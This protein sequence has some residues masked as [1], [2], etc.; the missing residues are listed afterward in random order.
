MITAKEQSLLGLTFIDLFAGLGG[1][2]LA[3][4]SFGAKCVYSSEWDVH[5]PNAYAENF[6]NVPD[7]DI[8]KADENAIPEHDILCAGF[9]C[10][11]FSISGKRRGFEDS[12]GTLFFDV[13]RIAK[14]KKP[15]A[16][17]MENVKNSATRDGGRTLEAVKS[18][19]E[20]IG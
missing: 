4:E 14:A 6:G 15:K 8:T 2:R 17:F 9:P 11:A 5:A 19:T 3:L 20:E 1:F 16:V 12:R 7:G 18:A 10:R 13:A